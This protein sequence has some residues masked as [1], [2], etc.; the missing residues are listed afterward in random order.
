MNTSWLFLLTLLGQAPNSQLIGHWAHLYAPIVVQDSQEPAPLTS[1]P[2]MLATHPQ[3]KG[4]CD[5]QTYATVVSQPDFW[6]NPSLEQRYTGCGSSLALSFAGKIT[7]LEHTAYY[8]VQQDSRYLY[9]QYWFFYA[10]NETGHLGGGP[11][12]AACGNHEGDWEHVSL[13][14][15]RDR[16]YAAQTP[17]EYRDAIDDV[18]FAQHQRHQHRERKYFRPDDPALSFSS[19]HVYVYPARGTHASYPHPGTW[20]LITIASLT[21]RDVN[22]GKGSVVDLSQADLEPVMHQ[23]WYPYPGRWGAVRDAG[24]NWVEAVTTASN[25]GAYGPGHAQKIPSF[26]QGDWYDHLRLPRQRR[27][28]PQ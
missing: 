10:W 18:Y 14:L 5:G 6:L 24:C 21:L 26:F 20:P 28:T 12:V 9:L 15:D 27:A 19:T 25:D 8:Q 23:P 4:Q 3:L 22:D 13:R 7:P 17:A 2:D 1:V 16:L 11:M